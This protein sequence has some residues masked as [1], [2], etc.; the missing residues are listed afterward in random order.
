MFYFKLKKLLIINIFYLFLFFNISNAEIVNKIVINGN[1]RVSDETIMVFSAV[2][3]G[4][5]I[6]AEKLNQIVNSLYDS[7]FFDNISTSL[8]NQELTITVKESPIINKVEFQGIKSKTLVESLSK[9]LSL[10]SRS[11]YNTYQLELDK[12]QIQNQLKNRGYYYS[13]IKIF[14]NIKD[15]NTLDLI[16]DINIGDKA[17]IKKITFSGNKIFKDSK[18]KSIIIS[19]EYKFWKFISGKKYLNE[20]IISVDNRLLKNFYLNQGYFNVKINSS[21]AK[22]IDKDSFELIFNIDADKR[23]FF[24][25]LTLKV[26]SDFDKSNYVKINSLFN[27]LKGEPYSINRIETILKKINEISIYEQYVSSEAFVEENIFEN[28]IDL[29]FIINEVQTV[30]VDKIN[31]LGNNVTKEVVIRNQLELDEGDPFNEI[32][33][34]R[35]INNIKGLNF[36]KDVKSEIID[37]KDNEAKIINISVEEKPTG[38]IMAG[39]GFGTSGTTTSFGIKENN[40]LGN[41]LSID[42]K[43]DLSEESIKGK[44]SLSNPNYKNSDKSV[45]TNIQSSETDRLED[46]GYKTNKTGFTLGTQFEYYDDFYFGVGINSYYESIETDSTASSQQKKLKGNYF[47]NFINLNFDYDKR[48][49]KFQPSQGFRNYFSTDLPIVSETNTLANTFITTNYFEYFDSNILKSSFYFRNSNSITGDNIKLSERLYLPSNRLRGFE[50]GK[51]G[52]KD[53]NDF[54]GGNYIASLNFSSNVPKLLENSQTTDIIMFFDVANVWGV[55]YDSALDTSDDI[56]SAI[57]LGLDW[58]SPIGPMN[59]TLSQHLSKGSN[60]VT[61][62]FRFN[63]G[64]TF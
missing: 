7:N 48:N 38:E 23:I 46:F 29:K 34:T 5:T 21:F 51:V 36:F 2:K 19:E 49:Q 37:N 42:A 62:S 45:Y 63:L 3:L 20:N 43:L 54:I 17:K 16:Y 35:S 64:T 39:A 15:N 25:N 61:E 18:L 26:P 10:K 57:G 58:F 9:N 40:Y 47:D 59:F 30:Q 12:L 60:D 27:D 24:N 1:E 6:N 31:I 8:N 50:S 41:G 33:F 56:K 55:D 44:F 22:S 13:K 32:L 4:D 53:G 28:K 52:P 14:T 11:S